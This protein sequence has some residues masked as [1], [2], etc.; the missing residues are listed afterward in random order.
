[1]VKLFILVNLLRG[2]L[3]L[4]SEIQY[5]K[6]V[7]PKRSSKLNKIGIYTIEDLLNYFPVRYEDRR[8]LSKVKDLDEENK[9]LLKVKIKRISPLK[10][11]NKKMSVFKVFAFDDTGYIN[12]TFFNQE[13]LYK[14]L[15]PEDIYFI[16]G[17]Y[18]LVEGVYEIVNP[19]VEAHNEVFKTGK[20]M[21]IYRLTNTLTNNEL[22]KLMITCIEDN[23]KRINNILPEHIIKEY[24]LLN[25]SD[26]VK[27]LHFPTDGKTYNQAKRT[28]AF[29]RLLIFQLGLFNIKN[30]LHS[31]AKGIV[32]DKT[33]LS[34]KLL[35]SLPYK[36]T[37]AQLR[38]IE[39]IQSDMSSNKAMNRLVQ[40]DVG[41][42][43]TIIAIIAMLNAVE[44]GYQ[45]TM[46]APTEILA[47]QHYQTI[48]EYLKNSDI[49]VEVAF[50]S[51]STTKKNKDDILKRLKNNEIDILIGTH[52]LIEK[53]VE[54]ANIGLAIT[55]EQHRFGVRQRA[56]LGNKRYEGTP[57]VLIMTATPIPRTLALMVYGDL[58]ISIIDEMPP[59]R[60]QII[61]KVLSGNK[62]DKAY[63]FIIDEIK[64]GRQAY[65]VAPLI[66]ESEKLELD[67]ATEIYE[68]LKNE[69]FSEFELGLLHGKMTNAEKD[70]IMER[71]YSGEIN[72]LVSTTVIE[73]GVNV[74]NATV[75]LILNAERFGLSQLHQL[76][77][78]VGRGKHQSYCILV[79]ESK[80]ANSKDRM[81][82]MAETNNGFLIAEEDLRLRGPGDFFGTR[83]S[84]IESYNLD[85]LIS[86]VTLVQDVQNITKKLLVEN[87]NLKGVEYDSL[88]YEI[89]KLFKNENI[90]FN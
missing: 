72:V 6:G 61:T 54:F 9:Y 63:E 81:K 14:K 42:G 3:M 68:S 16:Y 10:K 43:K 8:K 5:L 22:I 87:P 76:R 88:R 48:T 83:Q 84:G 56:M 46:M 24:N 64:K 21:P 38:V 45:A 50:L 39:E 33:S 7:G 78:R 60:Q 75:M 77:G 36:L 1:M 40:G 35:D 90:A 70:E 25:K 49:D 17:K 31:S 86:D 79:N 19:D 62:K 55:D 44:S 30:R 53:N 26:A 13:F 71:F 85:Q 11:I 51:G 4:N 23:C 32:Q 67:S 58:D 41:S 57:D 28:I 47:A 52:A 2:I 27:N 34:K 15:K 82:I 73:V 37:N 74:P 66:E 12:M 69:Y 29:E 20:I 80:S 59:N 18:K 89:L 65:I